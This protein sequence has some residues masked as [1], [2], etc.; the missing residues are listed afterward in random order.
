MEHRFLDDKIEDGQR[1]LDDVLRQID[2]LRRE[3]ALIEGELRAYAAIKRSLA[4]SP[5]KAVGAPAT[6][7][8]P[9]SDRPILP[10]EK[11]RLS[12]LWAS[13]FELVLK[14]YPGSVP[15][16]RL[17][18]LGEQH[19]KTGDRFRLPLHHHVTRR[20]LDK[21]HDDSYR[22]NQRTAER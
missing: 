2:D 17:K 4:S 19:G 16:E 8:P 5:L 12:P 20:N 18:N 9:R 11:T 13:V 10:G 22:A 1:R 15:L 14:A 3:A 6:P 21:L 7:N